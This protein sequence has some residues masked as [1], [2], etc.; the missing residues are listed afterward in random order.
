MIGYPPQ[1]YVNKQW[2]L[3]NIHSESILNKY[4]H[5]KVTASMLEY[6]QFFYLRLF[7]ENGT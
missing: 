2:V 5:W 4:D 6:E 7:F 1:N 3:H